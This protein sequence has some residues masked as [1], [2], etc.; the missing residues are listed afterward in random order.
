MEKVKPWQIVLFVAAIAAI[1]L[2]A[3]WSFGRGPK[4]KSTN[5]ALLVDVT[6]GELY[7]FSTKRKGVIIPERNPDSGKIA[8]FPV[9]KNDQGN[10][11]IES[12]Y[13]SDDAIEEV[14]GEPAN[15]DFS[16]GLVVITNENPKKV[17][18]K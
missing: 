10:W 9:S 5:E 13:L 2:G 12:R 15:V 17:T 11:M 6:T 1:V 8:L 16:T 7:A 14:E 4:A 18:A 3:W